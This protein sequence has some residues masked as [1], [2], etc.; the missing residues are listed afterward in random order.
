M[1]F[2]QILYAW[3][4]YAANP[5][6]MPPVKAISSWFSLAVTIFVAACA[7]IE[8]VFATS[9]ISATEMRQRT[10]SD[11]GNV[12]I[13]PTMKFFLYRSQ[14]RNMEERTCSCTTVRGGG[15]V[16]LISVLL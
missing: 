12:V 9:G 3:K 4:A 2:T 6:G 13:I 11:F 10:E 16:R 1:S 7:S 15:V 14:C 5:R 8:K